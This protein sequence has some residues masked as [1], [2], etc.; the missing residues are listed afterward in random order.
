M[1]TA[2]LISTFL[3]IM[4]IA[5]GKDMDKKFINDDLKLYDVTLIA[6]DVES[7]ASFYS[8]IG[9]GKHPHVSNE[10]I[11]IFPMPNQDLAIIKGDVNSSIVV[12]FIC[13]DLDPIE[14]RLKKSKVSYVG[15]KMIQ[16]GMKGIEVTDPNG[17]RINFLIKRD[18]MN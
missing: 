4:T 8:S 7:L 2:I 13:P 18:G 14:K 17:N 5:Q 12:S 16:A 15:P 3:F 9:F 11:V 1:K 6:K 10:S